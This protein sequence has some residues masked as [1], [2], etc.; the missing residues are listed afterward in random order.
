MYIELLMGVSVTPVYTQREVCAPTDPPPLMSP[1]LP[2]QDQPLPITPNRM[3]QLNAVMSLAVGGSGLSLAV[4]GRVT[5][6][7]LELI[8]EAEL[9]PGVIPASTLLL[10]GSSENMASL[11]LMRRRSCELV[12]TPLPCV[13]KAIHHIEKLEVKIEEWFLQHEGIAERRC[14]KWNSS[15]NIQDAVRDVTSESPV[16]HIRGAGLIDKDFL[17]PGEDLS[18][19][20][21]TEAVMS[22]VMQ[23]IWRLETEH[24]EAEEAL[25]L[26]KKRK[27]GLTTQIDVLSQWK[28]SNLPEAVQKEYDACAEDLSELKWHI[29][30]KK[31]E[32][33]K[34]QR[35]SAKTEAVNSKLEE[36]IDF[37]RKQRP[38]LDEKLNHEGDATSRIKQAQSEATALLNAAEVKLKASHMSFEKVTA[39]ANRER[40]DMAV[41]LAEVKRTLQI[42]RDNLHNAEN[43]W[44]ECTSELFNTD[45]KTEDGKKLYSELQSERQQVT[46]GEDSW[47]QQVVNLK[48]ELDDQ[49]K[50]NKDLTDVY[51]RHSQEAGIMESNFKSQLSDLEQQLHKELHALRDLEYENKTLNLENEDMS[52]KI[53][54]SY[55]MRSKLE[56]DTQRMQKSQLR[57]EE[58]TANVVKELSKVTVQ[59]TASK[60]KLAELEYQSS[61]EET[62]LKTLAE[63]LRKQVIEEVKAGQVT[64][65][66]INIMMAE[67]QQKQ[68][69]NNKIKEELVMAAEEIEQPLAQLE[70]EIVKLTHLHAKKS[71]IPVGYH[72]VIFEEVAVYITVVSK[73]SMSVPTTKMSS[74][75]EKRMICASKFCFNKRGITL[76]LMYIK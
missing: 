38:L 48:Y 58:Q 8:S 57:K 27:Q 71:E 49:E 75:L 67:R 4:F 60:E 72:V 64:L 5:I 37:I 17:C 14:I 7:L 51:S 55:K 19:K 70:A 15:E 24:Q 22:E 25:K 61:K 47:N 12:N 62:H 63:S 44:A 33:E 76:Q 66:R 16:L 2:A 29:C 34:A 54:N 13:N 74:G 18:L 32:L 10:E 28:L 45:R 35:K 6:E 40:S 11:D 20:L 36:E 21:H 43:I 30:C 50:K 3:L 39:E 26:E 68:R 41:Q 9:L 65:A 31:Q 69:E 42:C 1:L 59:H 46:E 56:A 73:D 23:L 52:I 53:S